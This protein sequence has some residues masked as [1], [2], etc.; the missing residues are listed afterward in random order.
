M[1]RDRQRY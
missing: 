1:D